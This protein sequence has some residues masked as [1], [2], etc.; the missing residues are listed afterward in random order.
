MKKRIHILLAALLMAMAIPMQAQIVT[1]DDEE[2]LRAPGDLGDWGRIPNHGVEYDQYNQLAPIGEGILLLA[3]LG[4][5]Y[6]VGKKR[7]E[8]Q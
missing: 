3:A 8:E 2:N 6:L 4:G 7:K 5:A 1:M